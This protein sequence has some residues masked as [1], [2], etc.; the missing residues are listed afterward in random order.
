MAHADPDSGSVLIP[1]QLIKAHTEHPIEFLTA[2]RPT[3]FRTSDL[4]DVDISHAGARAGWKI[5]KRDT[6][7]LLSFWALL[8]LYLVMVYVPLPF[9]PDILLISVLLVVVIGATIAVVRRAYL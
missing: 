9:D 3:E 5:S 7:A 8:G 2:G 6:F 1:P 4:I